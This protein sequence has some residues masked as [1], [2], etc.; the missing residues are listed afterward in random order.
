MLILYGSSFFLDNDLPG[1]TNEIF[2]WI[3]VVIGTLLIIF[4]FYQYTKRNKFL[5]DGVEA[6]KCIDRVG[7]ASLI[8]SVL[9]VIL[10]GTIVYKHIVIH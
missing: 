1:P 3:G 4:A 5:I 6:S 9:G 10:A 8:G 2:G 7:T